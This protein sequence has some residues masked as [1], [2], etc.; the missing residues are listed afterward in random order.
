MCEMRS[1]PQMSK[2]FKTLQQI[3]K[4]DFSRRGVKFMSVSHSSYFIMHYSER[5]NIFRLVLFAD[6]RLLQP[7]LS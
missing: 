5:L 3:L 4:Q 6:S 2:S 1:Q 7:S